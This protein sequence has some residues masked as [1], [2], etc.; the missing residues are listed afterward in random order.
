MALPATFRARNA[1]LILVVG[2]P[3][4]LFG[5]DATPSVDPP[6]KSAPKEFAIDEWRIWTSPFKR[7]S[8]GSH[9]FKKY[10]VPFV[11]VTG[12]LIATDRKI[13]QALPNSADQIKWSGR[14]SQIGG[15]YGVAGITVSTFLAGKLADDNRLKESGLLGLE[16]L[17]HAQIAVFAFKEMTNRQ[18]PT[19]S[20]RR[21]GFWE[22]GTSFPSGHAASAFSVATVFAYEYHDHVAVPIVAYSLASLVAASRVS[23]DRHWVSDVVAGSA[24]GFLMGRFTYKR[25]HGAEGHA[26]V[27]PMMTFANGGPSLSWSF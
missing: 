11:L 18:R 4:V 27:V 17:G 12:A 25:R 9:G 23:A 10:V 26:G 6:L 16:A 15:V 1:L 8:Y 21:G 7:Q 20:D 19:D 5:Q 3:S 2:V 13:T 14:V 22:G 24:L